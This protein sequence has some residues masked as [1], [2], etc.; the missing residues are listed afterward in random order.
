MW[1]EFVGSPA[2]PVFPSPQKPIF[3]LTGFEFI[4]LVPPISALVLNPLTLK[5]AQTSVNT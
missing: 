3:D 1:V 5:V 2:T 4:L